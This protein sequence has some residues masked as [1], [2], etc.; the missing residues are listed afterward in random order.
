MKNYITLE[1][2]KEI[3]LA[4]SEYRLRDMQERVSQL[5]PFKP[6]CKIIPLVY[7]SQYEGNTHFEYITVFLE[8]KGVLLVPHN[9][10]N[11]KTFKFF[12]AESLGR[13]F[14]DHNLQ[15]PKKVGVPTEKKLD[16]WLEYLLQIE[17]LRKA[18]QKDKENKE[19]EFLNKIKNCG[20]PIQHATIDGKSGYLITEDIEYYFNI[21]NNG[22]IEQKIR[23]RGS[24]TLEN[25]LKLVKK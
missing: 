24:N 11:E 1:Q 12:L 15:E 6:F 13:R 10:Y 23:L 14:D 8:Y 7:T 17:A 16:L 5:E 22:Y 21:Q 19:T 2:A 9:N 20:I 25:F 3:G 4:I 18:A